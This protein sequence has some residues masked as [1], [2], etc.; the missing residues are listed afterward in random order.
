MTR[1]TLFA[2]LNPQVSA[3][4]FAAQ[5]NKFA[6][7][8]NEWNEAYRAGVFRADLWKRADELWSKLQ[9]RKR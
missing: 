4:D 7:T 8:L 2:L 1:R 6:E 3:D 5:Y 9:G